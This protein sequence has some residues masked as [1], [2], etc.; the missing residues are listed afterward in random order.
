MFCSESSDLWA[1]SC[2]CGLEGMM[3]RA[4]CFA[5]LVWWISSAR[6]ISTH[7]PLVLCK[8]TGHMALLRGR[9]N[10]FLDVLNTTAIYFGRRNALWIS[11]K[12]S[13]LFTALCLEKIENWDEDEIG[14]WVT[15]TQN[16]SKDSAQDGPQTF[17]ETSAGVNGFGSTESWS[18][19]AV[20]FFK[21]LL[22]QQQQHYNILDRPK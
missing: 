2:G 20:D 6:K 16:I 15:R 4:L 5:P 22:H 11:G 9:N 1:L 14:C 8:I 17:I 18:M 21:Y 13:C 10:L 19:F 7:F 3:I 12:R